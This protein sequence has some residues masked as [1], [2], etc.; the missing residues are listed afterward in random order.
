M[1]TLIIFVTMISVFVPPKAYAID[2][3]FVT[4][5]V[6]VAVPV[7]LPVVGVRL[8]TGETVFSLY[9]ADNATRNACGY[10]PL[11]RFDRSSLATNQYVAARSWTIDGGRCVESVVVSNRVPKITLSRVKVAALAKA[12]GWATNLLDYIH[13]DPVVAVRWYSAEPL[14]AGSEEMRPHIEAFGALVGLPYTN[15][16]QMLEQCRE[17]R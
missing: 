14:V 8:D 16:V 3:A 12:N 9:G 13:G 1:K 17:D 2:V 15:A 10:Y 7:Q 11:V 4:N 5:G 6:I